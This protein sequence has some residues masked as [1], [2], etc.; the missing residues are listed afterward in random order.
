MNVQEQIEEYIATQPEPKR[1]DMQELHNLALHVLPGCKL[2]FDNGT[3]SENKTVSNPTIG[4][5]LH[6]MKY[7]D[8]TTRDVFNI[9]LSANKTGISV[10]IIGIKDKTYLSRTY[11]NTLGKAS[12]T[13][14]CIRFKTLKDV[15]VDILEAAIRY[16]VKAAPVL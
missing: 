14:Y 6:T 7:A 8:G 1:S 11:G 4:Y 9:G 15:N 13:G 10:Y 2:W 16:G 3:N 5:G 12:V